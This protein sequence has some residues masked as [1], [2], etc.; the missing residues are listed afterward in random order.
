MQLCVYII[1][2]ADVVL[3]RKKV[4]INHKILTMVLNLGIQIKLTPE[5][6]QSLPIS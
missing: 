6:A 5:L 4:E 2:E 1:G 3:K